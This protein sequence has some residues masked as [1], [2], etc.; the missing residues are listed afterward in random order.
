M[1]LFEGGAADVDALPASA[2]RNRKKRKANTNGDIFFGG[3][4][5]LSQ[6]CRPSESTRVV[7]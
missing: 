3:A 6:R 2:N 5:F 4:T 1:T 7:D